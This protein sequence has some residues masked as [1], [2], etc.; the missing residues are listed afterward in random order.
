MDPCTPM[1]SR[2]CPIAIEPTE[3]N[4]KIDTTRGSMHVR[5][6]PH[7]Q[8]ELTENDDDIRTTHVSVPLR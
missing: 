1:G 6:T 4:N 3:N 8:T 7:A 2:A 5:N